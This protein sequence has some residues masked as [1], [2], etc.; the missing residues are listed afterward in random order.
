M[1]YSSNKR[2]SM[3]MRFALAVCLMLVMGF[4]LLAAEKIG[5]AVY[6]E[7]TVT[8]VRDGEEMDPSEVQIGMDIN[9]YDMLKTGAGALAEIKVMTTKAPAMTIKMSANTQYS[10]E[11][12]KLGTKT[13][14]SIGLI[15]GTLSL[16]V[17]KLTGTQAVNVKTDSAAMG[18]RGTGFTVTA[19][20]SGD[21]LVTCDEGEVFCSEESGEELSVTPGKAV[22]KKAGERF[23]SMPVAV[24]DLET[25]RTNWNAER[26]SALKSNAPKAI[27][28]FAKQYLA[29]S[30]ELQTNF[31][32]LMKLQNV[33][34]KWEQEDRTGKPG[35]KMDAMKEK[36][37][38]VG[39]LFKLRKTLFIFERIYYRLVELREYYDQGFGKGA[40]VQP[41]M[42]VD[43]FFKRMDGERKDLEKKMAKIRQVAK[44]YAERNDGR[45]PTGAFDDN[46][47]VDEEDFF[48][49]VDF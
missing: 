33:I 11:L 34:S 8:I 30:A 41:G 9:N 31:T 12:S 29:L 13:Q 40:I 16:K 18:V 19:P 5:E 48:G 26:I 6:L 35:G 39:V 20:S 22:E 47:E 44:F 43:Q 24:S 46:E 28:N 49:G 42:T 25:F 15:T 37:E 3:K 10:L 27:P 4:P 32:A 2:D 23:R 36:K 21:I 17:S 1:V 38:I 14:S 45:A 7:G